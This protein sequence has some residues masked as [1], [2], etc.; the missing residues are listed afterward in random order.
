MRTIIIISDDRSSSESSLEPKHVFIG[1]FVMLLIALV[2]CWDAAIKP[3]YSSNQEMLVGITYTFHFPYDTGLSNAN[4]EH[5]LD[6]KVVW[7]IGSRQQA[8]KIGREIA[9]MYILYLI[10]NPTSGDEGI[11]YDRARYFT[12]Y[13][14][15][16]KSFTEKEHWDEPGFWRNIDENQRERLRALGLRG[17]SPD[18]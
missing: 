3:W 8:Q 15:P 13:S 1:I 16:V 5:E 9:S 14:S 17:P 7:V 2:L 18:K 6:D 11:V 10:K 12:A 4:E